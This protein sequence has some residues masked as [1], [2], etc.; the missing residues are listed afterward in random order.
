MISANNHSTD[1]RT[2]L[3]FS[4]KISICLVKTPIRLGDGP[5]IN[6]F[7]FQ[8]DR[9]QNFPNHYTDQKLPTFV[10]RASFLLSKKKKKEKS[11][12]N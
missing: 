9:K 1:A 2:A 10:H 7:L 11:F 6:T 5:H 12:K 8:L 3:F 4:L